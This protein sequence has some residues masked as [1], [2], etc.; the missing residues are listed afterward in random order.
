MTTGPDLMS[1]Y[2][3]PSAPYQYGLY[4]RDYDI[5]YPQP[6]QSPYKVSDTPKFTR[7]PLDPKGIPDV[8]PDDRAMVPPKP[9]Q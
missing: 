7:P 5:P 1:D 8:A 6:P 3:H 9:P 4:R 2:A